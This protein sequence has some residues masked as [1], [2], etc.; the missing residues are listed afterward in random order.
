MESTTWGTTSGSC[1][2]GL[3]RTGLGR[4]GFGWEIVA[5]VVGMREPVAGMREPVAVR[6]TVVVTVQSCQSGTLNTQSRVGIVES[7]TQVVLQVQ[8]HQNSMV[9][10]SVVLHSWSL[11]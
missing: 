8:V 9:L 10:H 7:C 11:V 1:L 5:A 2:M 3:G 6:Q 4:T